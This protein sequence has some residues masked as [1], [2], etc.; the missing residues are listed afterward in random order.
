MPLIN[1]KTDL[2]SL[3]FGKD[4]P[5]GGSSQ[6]PF[7]SKTNIDDIKTE[8]LGRSGGPDFLLRGGLLTPIRAAEDASR[9]FQLFTKTNTGVLFTAKQNLLSRIGTDMD[10]GYP[11][12]P[13]KF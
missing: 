5:G 4:R 2:K 7:I 11:E 12:F 3:K 10:G 13:I 1:L 8:D 6:Q 9:L